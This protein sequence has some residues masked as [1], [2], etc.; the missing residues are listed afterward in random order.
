MG[1]F[2]KTVLHELVLARLRRAIDVCEIV[3][4]HADLSLG[5]SAATGDDGRS[6]AHDCLVKAW[7]RLGD[8]AIPPSGG[9]DGRCLE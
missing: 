6:H 4:L 3:T 7:M 9:V 8:L 5:F 2:D 1:D